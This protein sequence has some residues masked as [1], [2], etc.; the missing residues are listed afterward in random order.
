MMMIAVVQR[1]QVAVET[2]DEGVGKVIDN[3]GF[4]THGDTGDAVTVVG[5]S[6]A[7]A[8]SAKGGET[9]LGCSRTR[10]KLICDITLMIL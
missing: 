10:F 8:T 2:L 7:D 4:Q 1:C 5:D 3:I 9:Q 6:G